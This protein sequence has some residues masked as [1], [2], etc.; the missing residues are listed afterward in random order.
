M[1]GALRLCNWTRCEWKGT[2]NTANTSYTTTPLKKT[3]SWVHP[4]GEPREKYED[5]PV[6]SVRFKDAASS[7]N[8]QLLYERRKFIV[9]KTQLV[10][11]LIIGGRKSELPQSLIFSAFTLPVLFAAAL[12]K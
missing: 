11:S 4:L 12:N 3:Y 5:A 7:S 6:S 1:I 9:L 8:Q 2:R 10:P